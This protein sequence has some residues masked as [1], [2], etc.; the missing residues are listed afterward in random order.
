MTSHADDPHRTPAPLTDA[1]TF[2]NVVGRFATGVTVVTARHD[3]TDHGMTANAVT[4]LSLHPPMLLV[5]IHR[6][7]PTGEA[8]RRSGTFVVNVLAEDQADLARRFATRMR[9]KF[10]GVDVS[11]GILGP[12]RIAGA[13]AYLE[14][15]LDQHTEGGT[16][17]V[18][19]ARVEHAE[20]REGA[21]LIFFRGRY[22]TLAPT[23]LSPLR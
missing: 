1:R 18:F 5:C 12:P 10:A 4:S 7:S 2:R 9:D 19:M 13:L 11:P 3:G 22:T 23:A 16:H 20:G 15:R 21:P 6:A 8:V 17:T 14:C